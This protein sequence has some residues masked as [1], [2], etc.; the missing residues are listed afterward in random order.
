[1]DTRR[2]FRMLAYAQ[3]LPTAKS[4]ARAERDAEMSLLVVEP[5][6]WALELR[7]RLIAL[8]QVPGVL[9]IW[10]SFA[11]LLERLGYRTW[12]GI[13]NAADHGVPQ[14]RRRA[15]LLANLS[16]PVTPPVPTHCRGGAL[17]LEGE[18][19]PWVSMAQAL[20]W[21]MKAEQDAPRW[22]QRSGQSV[23]GEGRAERDLDGPSVT[24]H[25]RA[26]LNRWV[27]TTRGKRNEKTGG[28]EFSADD[29]SWS[30]TSSARSRTA[31][32]LSP[33]VS[34]S[35]PNRRLY[36]IDEP[37]PTVA[38][39]HDAAGWSWHDQSALLHTNRGQDEHGNRQ[40][41]DGGRR[42][43]TVSTKSG[44]QWVFERP[45]TTVAGDPSLGSPGHRDR[46]GGER[47]FRPDAIRI[48]IQEAAI[49]QGFPPDYPWQGSRTKQFAQVGNAIPP[50]LALAVLKA[51]IA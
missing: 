39:A 24:I 15:F 19:L 36:P 31:R 34:E 12:C 38:F 10:R 37:A 1:M 28:N 7:P 18:L 13:L 35:Q 22:T 29:V 27:V 8:E 14:T 50:P 21:E 16:G 45:A 25:G 3:L 41:V 46:E 49:L 48:T 11:L 33:G 47:Q 6:R 30:L 4:D 20:G 44:G 23:N 26:D 9:P 43:P 32:C 51:L 17:T 2:E 5:F 42:P 40:A